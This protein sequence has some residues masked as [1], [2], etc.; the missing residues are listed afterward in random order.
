MSLFKN[1]NRYISD[2]NMYA[3]VGRRCRK[4]C[5]GEIQHLVPDQSLLVSVRLSTRAC[6]Q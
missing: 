5:W 6:W 1:S 2:N 3:T 4:L